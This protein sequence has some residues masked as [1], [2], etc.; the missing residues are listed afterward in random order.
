MGDILVI[1]TEA[2]LSKYA[3]TAESRRYKKILVKTGNLHD[4]SEAIKALDAAWG[5]VGEGDSY[6]WDNK[7]VWQKPKSNQLNKR[8][9][10]WAG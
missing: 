8:K 2:W 5:I 4:L 7:A 3:E 9:T 10:S 6:E 1:E